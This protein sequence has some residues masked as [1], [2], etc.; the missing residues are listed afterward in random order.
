MRFKRY[1]PAQLERISLA[2]ENGLGCCHVLSERIRLAAK[3]VSETMTDAERQAVANGLLRVPF[4][5]DVLKASVISNVVATS[6]GFK[7]DTGRRCNG[8]RLSDDEAVALIAR[9]VYIV[10]G[11]LSTRPKAKKT[12][13]QFSSELRRGVYH[14]LVRLPA[15]RPKAKATRLMAGSYYRKAVYPLI[16]EAIKH[17]ATRHKLRSEVKRLATSKGIVIPSESQLGRII[18]GFFKVDMTT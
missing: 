11:H 18:K 3:A 4:V 13:L 14:T 12:R 2:T 1:N 5:D 6:S 8:R 9:P 17:G 10:G 15:V 7:R 16:L